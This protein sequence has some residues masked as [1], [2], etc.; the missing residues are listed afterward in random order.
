MPDLRK[1]LFGI[2]DQDYVDVTRLGAP[3]KRKAPF[4]LKAKFGLKP[5]KKTLSAR[6]KVIK[7]KKVKPSRSV[8]K[9]AKPSLKSVKHSMKPVKPL[10]IALKP[11]KRPKAIEPQL[12]A[13]ILAGEVTHFFDKIKVCVI[14]PE[15]ILKVGDQL[16]FKGSVTDFRQRLDSM[17]IDHAPVMTASKGSEVGLK[18]KKEVRI[19]DKVFFGA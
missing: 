6:L 19:G 10:K 5:K 1:I 7:I 2:R 3:S 15:R 12:K 14:K 17:Q 16:H 4:V 9:L 13:E 11:Q 18:V 8:S